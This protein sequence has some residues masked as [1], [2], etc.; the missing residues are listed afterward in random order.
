MNYR[1]LVVPLVVVVLAGCKVEIKVPEGGSIISSTGI[2]GCAEFETCTLDIDHIY[3]TEDLTAVPKQGYEFRWWRK[4]DGSFCGGNRDTKCALTTD[5]FPD[6]PSLFSLLST[7]R[8]FTLTPV[9]VYGNTLLVPPQTN[10][11]WTATSNHSAV[12][13]SVYGD[14]AAAVYNSLKSDDNPLEFNSGE[15]FKPDGYA[16]WKYTYNYWYDIS[17]NGKTCT[18]TRIE[19]EFN[20]TTTLPRLAD[21]EK[22]SEY[23]KSKWTA[24]QE[25]LTEH[26]AGHQLI[27]RDITKTVPEALNSVGPQPCGELN[28]TLSQAATAAWKPMAQASEDY[29]IETNHGGYTIPSLF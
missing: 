18:V 21:L 6:Y 20:F 17:A 13:Y 2:Y 29:D 9:F 4:G 27:F 23:L 12:N 15:G 5:D 11:K 19:I 25:G 26:E 28:E 10:R 7:D 3:F 24:Y 22:K 8:V 1:Y 16:Q 14:T